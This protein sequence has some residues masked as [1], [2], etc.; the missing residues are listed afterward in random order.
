MQRVNFG[1]GS[2][3]A[4]AVVLAVFFLTGCAA[5]A[6]PERVYAASPVYMLAQIAAAPA[7]EPV[8]DTQGGWWRQ[9]YGHRT[10]EGRSSTREQRDW[11]K[12]HAVDPSCAGFWR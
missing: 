11:C 1:T 4:A 2:A 10:Y 9:H 5:S 3:V 7:V 12:R 6:T 8:A